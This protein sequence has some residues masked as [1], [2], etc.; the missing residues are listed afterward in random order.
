VH[1]R[2]RIDFNYQRDHLLGRSSSYWNIVDERLER[3]E[4]VQYDGFGERRPGRAFVAGLWRAV[5]QR[6]LG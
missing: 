5:L 1:A 3:G 6:H 4:H 2:D